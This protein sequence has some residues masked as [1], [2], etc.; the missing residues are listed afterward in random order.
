MST[1]LKL[2]VSSFYYTFF[3]L[4]SKLNK[5]QEVQ[6]LK[7]MKVICSYL[8]DVFIVIVCQSQQDL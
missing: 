2:I 5:V 3:Q 6:N 7:S 1:G 8:L 4:P